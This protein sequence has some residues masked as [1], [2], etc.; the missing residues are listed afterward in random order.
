MSEID[1]PKGFD[2]QTWSNPND[3]IVYK[4][5]GTC[6]CCGNNRDSHMQRAV[7]KGHKSVAEAREWIRREYKV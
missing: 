3:V 5:V 1:I 2:I 6:K 7:S 4:E